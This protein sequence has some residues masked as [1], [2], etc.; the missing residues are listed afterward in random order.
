MFG[1]IY[2]G[3]QTN[4]AQ[5]TSQ[6]LDKTVESLCTSVGIKFVPIKEWR[7]PNSTYNVD[8]GVHHFPTA[9]GVRSAHCK[10]C[11]LFSTF[12]IA[13]ALKT[14]PHL[15]MVVSQVCRASWE[16]YASN[17]NVECCLCNVIVINS[18]WRL[19][20]WNA[21]QPFPHVSC[22]HVCNIKLLWIII[23]AAA[24]HTYEA[25]DADHVIAVLH[26]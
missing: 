11:T 7:Q 13:K 15:H 25:S 3:N 4:L 22:C 26:C 23:T 9:T 17:G 2:Q 10:S 16:P 14:P 1:F 24:L 21:P 5:F 18:W 20:R 8:V 12:T 19:I 6:K